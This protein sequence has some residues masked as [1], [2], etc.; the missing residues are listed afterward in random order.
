[1]SHDIPADEMRLRERT[2]GFDIVSIVSEER[3]KIEVMLRARNGGEV[4]KRV[5][6]RL[7]VEGS[8]PFGVLRFEI[9]CMGGG[10]GGD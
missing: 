7:E 4:E 2:G 9:Q 1:V 8:E 5:K 10:D 3:T 6:I